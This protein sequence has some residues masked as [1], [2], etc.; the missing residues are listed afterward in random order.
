MNKQ[1]KF[2]D[3]PDG[4][5]PPNRRIYENAKKPF[6]WLWSFVSWMGLPFLQ[7]LPFTMLASFVV[8]VFLHTQDG[9]A[10]WSGKVAFDVIA[11]GL[12]WMLYLGG[13]FLAIKFLRALVR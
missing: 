1:A 9:T 3:V 7:A 12:V 2:C 6:G 5:V 8:N 10:L 4:Y 11:V 13:L